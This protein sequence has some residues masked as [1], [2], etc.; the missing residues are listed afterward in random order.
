MPRKS[1]KCKILSV[2]Y[3]ESRIWRLKKGIREANTN[4]IKILRRTLKK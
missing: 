2:K 4:K 3:L 1:F